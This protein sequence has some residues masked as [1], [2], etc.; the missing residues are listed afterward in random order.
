MN[1]KLSNILLTFVVGLCLLL[2]VSYNGLSKAEA[3]IPLLTGAGSVLGLLSGSGGVDN[4]R[5]VQDFSPTSITNTLKTTLIEAVTGIMSGNITSLNMK[6]TVLDPLAWQLGKQLQQQITGNMLE[7]LG[8]QLPGQNGKVPFIQNYSEH[9]RGITEEVVGDY[10]F[11]NR[12]GDADRSCDTE[13]ANR[14]LTTA[15]N[16]YMSQKQNSEEGGA[17]RCD[18]P[19]ATAY[20]S[21]GDQILGNFIECRDEMCAYYTTQKELAQRNAKA[22][23][24]ERDLVNIS[25]GLDLKT[26]RLCREVTT[27]TGTTTECGLINPP[28]FA[29]DAASFQINQVPS[30]QLLQID[31]VSEVV[32][33]LMSSLTTQALTGLTGVLGLSGNSAFGPSGD[34]SYARTLAQDDIGANIM[35]TS[36]PIKA[37]L[38]A[39]ID[40]ANMQS[41]VIDDITDLETSH[42]AKLSSYGSCFNIPLNPELATAKATATIELQNASSTNAFLASLDAAYTAATSS[43]V[44]SALTSA[45]VDIQSKGFTRNESTN[46]QWKLQ[47]FD[48]QLG[49]L[50]IDKFE[51]DMA[52]TEVNSCSASCFD[53]QGGLPLPSGLSACTP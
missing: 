40:Y 24:I 51:Y 48:Y 53:Y 30:L 34:L 7:W 1:M 38:K 42:A 25:K 18:N 23:E 44:R 15:Y 33:N 52:V 3:I 21:V 4:V 27:S 6:E 50:L 14:V 28:S 37:A 20:E 22:L 17:L 35:G 10:L 13:Y 2:P 5:I 26:Q 46:L 12:G 49:M 19:G 39:G 11:T 16:A 41:Q 45:F 9:Y 43:A 36:S 8:G 32:S 47:I 29:M 31:E